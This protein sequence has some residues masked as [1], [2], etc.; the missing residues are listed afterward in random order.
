MASKLVWLDAFITNVDRTRLN[1]NMM[2]WKG[3]LWLIDHGASLYFHHSDKDPIQAAL[4]PFPYI[5]N[6][7]FLPFANQL[8]EA[9]KLM[10]QAITPRTLHKIVEKIPNEWLRDEEGKRTPDEIRNIYKTYLTKR[11][12]ESS[13]FVAQAIRERDYLLTTQI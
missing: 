3:E 8:K 7:I 9:D 1:P 6:H 5:R 2:I 4:D 11:L 10:R 13:L 12:A